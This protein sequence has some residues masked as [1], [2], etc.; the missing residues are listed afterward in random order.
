MRSPRLTWVSEGNPRFRLLVGS[1]AEQIVECVVGFHGDTSVPG[2]GE[3][4]LKLAAHGKMSAMASD[5][6]GAAS[7]AKV[8]VSFK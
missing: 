2:N 4:L 8:S 7:G 6:S 5:T 1:K 3:M